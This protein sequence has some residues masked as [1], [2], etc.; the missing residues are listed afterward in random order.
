MVHVS[1][2]IYL[3]QLRAQMLVKWA[4]WW[5]KEM[6][7][8]KSTVS[9]P[10]L[11]LEGVARLLICDVIHNNMVGVLQLWI[12]F[13][14]KMIQRISNNRNERLEDLCRAADHLESLLGWS[15]K[16]LYKTGTWMFSTFRLIIKESRSSKCGCDSQNLFIL[17]R[18]LGLFYQ[19]FSCIVILNK[20]FH[21]FSC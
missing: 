5:N 9:F 4:T 3:S 8:K 11:V 13:P 18:R 21:S 17:R 2:F 19:C 10:S 20:M 1:V 15:K 6:F 14:H 7:D 12:Y 16:S